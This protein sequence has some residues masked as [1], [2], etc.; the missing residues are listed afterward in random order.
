MNNLLFKK[1]MEMFKMG[2]GNL[3]KSVGSF[4]KLFLNK[5]ATLQV[6]NI[7]IKL[8]FDNW[9]YRIIIIIIPLLCHFTI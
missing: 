3:Q 7:M 5:I 1:E 8:L 4:V 2:M 9:L 6:T